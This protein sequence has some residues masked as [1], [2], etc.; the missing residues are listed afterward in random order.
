M[1]TILQ[2]LLIGVLLMVILALLTSYALQVLS[3]VSLEVTGTLFPLQSNVVYIFKGRISPES[4]IVEVRARLIESGRIWSGVN[5]TIE[6]FIQEDFKGTLEII[7]MG[8]G[9]R[10]IANGSICL[11]IGYGEKK[12]F[13]VQLNWLPN[14]T[15]EQALWG[16][17]VLKLRS[18]RGLFLAP[19]S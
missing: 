14:Y 11:E 16:R 6:N 3:P 13:I 17:L 18:R 19:W 12:Q 7:I 5:V 9:G 15:M 8:R 1:K 10:I 4:P 2:P